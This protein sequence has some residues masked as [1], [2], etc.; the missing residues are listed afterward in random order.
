MDERC[1]ESRI[2][3]DI[4]VLG[5]TNYLDVPLRMGPRPL[6][7]VVG[8]V[9][10]T[11][12]EHSAGAARHAVPNA[13]A[14]RPSHR[15]DDESRGL[16]GASERA[17]LRVAVARGLFADRAWLALALG[18]AGAIL[19]GGPLYWRYGAR[20]AVLRAFPPDIGGLRQFLTRFG[21][22]THR[23]EEDRR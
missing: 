22:R 1:I 15:H 23:S 21:S 12:H 18:S 14:V 8:A 2:E 11:D 19:L 10:R 16:D 4:S 5:E 9:A 3:R 13:Q 17:G 6:V 7:E 20:E